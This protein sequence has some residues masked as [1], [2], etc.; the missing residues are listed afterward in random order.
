[1]LTQCQEENGGPAALFPTA[2]ETL[3]TPSSRNI[4]AAVDVQEKLL[5]MK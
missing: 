1:M 5:T 4:I 2:R 3:A